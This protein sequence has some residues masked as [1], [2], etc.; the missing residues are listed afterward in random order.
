M[1]LI[2]RSTR[3]PNGV[4]RPVVDV[5]EVIDVEE[6][7]AERAAA[8]PRARDLARERLLAA[9][10][11]REA[12]DRI[13]EGEARQRREPFLRLQPLEAGL[14]LHGEALRCVG[15]RVHAACVERERLAVEQAERP[16]DRVVAAH[17]G[18]ADVAA[19]RARRRKHVLREHRVLQHVGHDER[20]AALDHL[21]HERPGAGRGPRRQ[22]PRRHVDVHAEP[23]LLADQHRHDA[24]R[25]REAA[26]DVGRHAVDGVRD[27]PLVRSRPVR[28]RAARADRGHGA[29]RRATAAPASRAPSLRPRR[30]RAV[31]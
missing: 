9:A 7:E 15:E 25:R 29:A 18:D 21:P 2:P 5:L 17:D 27:P 1:S 3:S 30:R 14:Q 28:P 4:P 26:R 6:R 24:R 20:L 11:V 8:A 16:V 12:R 13:G 31:R 19:Q 10:P 23:L 22:R